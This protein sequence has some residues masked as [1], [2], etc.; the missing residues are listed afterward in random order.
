NNAILERQLREV[1]DPALNDLLGRI[2]KIFYDS[3]YESVVVEPEEVQGGEWLALRLS[4]KPGL[5]TLVEEKGKV[6]SL[7]EYAGKN[8]ESLA[9]RLLLDSVRRY[10]GKIRVINK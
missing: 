5:D 7:R 4:I 8:S 1:G 6:T 9:C 10:R 2:D 3:K